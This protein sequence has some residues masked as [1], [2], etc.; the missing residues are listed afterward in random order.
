M[1]V[2]LLAAAAL[3]GAA[4]GPT[5]WLVTDYLEQ[6][7]DFCNACHLEPDVPLHIELRRHFDA[8][9]PLTL[10]GAHASEGDEARADRAFRCIDCHGGV[11]LAGRTRVK[12]LAAADAFWY[13]VGRF[14]EPAGMRFPLWDED[15]RQCHEGF[16]ERAPESLRN[17]AFHELAVH[18]AKLGVDCVA[19]HFAHDLGGDADAW[20]LHAPRVRAECAR[21]HSEFEEGSP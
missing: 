4:A 5:G 1:W 11:G 17:P 9:P 13:V 8:R 20:F 7:N 2:R 19:C 16:D 18:N 3:A 10:A 12:A 21:C 15:C 14:D 6:D